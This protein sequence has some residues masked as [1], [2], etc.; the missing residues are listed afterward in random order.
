MQS[1]STTIHEIIKRMAWYKQNVPKFLIYFIIPIS[2]T[3][4]YSYWKYPNQIYFTV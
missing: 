2:I 1:K 4:N 3:H